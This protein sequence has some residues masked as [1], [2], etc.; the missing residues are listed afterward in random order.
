MVLLAKRSREGTYVPP[1]QSDAEVRGVHQPHS[2]GTGT[3]SRLS[4]SFILVPHGIAI[5]M[6]PHA[7]A[8]KSGEFQ[9]IRYTHTETGIYL[10][11]IL[12]A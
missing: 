4:I 5:G 12:M 6:V 3:N 11:G 10:Y 1:F 2:P 8:R 7:G 9:D